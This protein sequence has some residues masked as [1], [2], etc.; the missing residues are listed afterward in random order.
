VSARERILAAAGAASQGRQPHPGAFRPSPADASWDAFRTAL[1]SIAAEADGPVN[2]QELPDRVRSWRT[3]FGGGRCVAE[4]AALDLLG[5]GPWESAAEADSPH[6]FQDVDVGIALGALGVAE[7]GAVV[8][9][10]ELAPHRALLMLC[11]RLILIVDSAQVVADMHAAVA[12]LGT[13]A[14][15]H[16]HTTW[17]AGPSKTADIEQALVVGAHG[18]RALAV[19]GYRIAGSRP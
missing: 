17:I 9:T 19:I 7:N 3:R 1:E 12:R 16:H 15:R 13:D 4:P 5:P 2:R 10:G 14:S 11:E 18:P 6:E 8:V